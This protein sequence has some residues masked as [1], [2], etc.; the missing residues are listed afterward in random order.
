MFTG[1]F[2][3]QL[4]DKGRLAMPPLFRA[5]LGEQCY[6]TMGR[7]GCLAVWP[8][9]AFTKMVDA[10]IERVDRGEA[11]LQEQRLLA[12][13][14]HLVTL[15]KQGR[16]PIDERLRRAAGLANPTSDGGTDG[17]TAVLVSGNV[18]VVEL[19]NPEQHAVVVAAGVREM[20]GDL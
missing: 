1:T 12:G 20:A 8:V 19:W 13:S 9:P 18:R 5:E 11:S 2:E 4:D 3:R 6:V 15:D 10:L 7:N 17:S 16:I 14:A